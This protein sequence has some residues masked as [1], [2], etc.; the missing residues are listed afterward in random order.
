MGK[1]DLI[2]WLISNGTEVL[3]DLAIS[4]LKHFEDFLRKEAEKTTNKLDD[5]LVGVV[6][7]WFAE[8]LKDLKKD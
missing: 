2:K 5:Q 7:E 4:N 8:Y 6:I 3:I 1:D